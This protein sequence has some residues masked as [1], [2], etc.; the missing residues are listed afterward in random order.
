M[1]RHRF[2]FSVNPQLSFPDELR[3]RLRTQRLELTAAQRQ[4]AA[5]AAAERL[6]AS[7]WFAEAS[8]IAGYWA[9]KGELN[10]MPVLERALAQGKTVYLPVLA[11]DALQFAPWH[12]DIAMRRNRFQI[13]EPDV[14]SD[15]WLPPSALDLALTPL[16]AFDA[17]NAVVERAGL[18]VNARHVAQCAPQLSARSERARASPPVG[19]VRLRI[20]AS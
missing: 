13:P 1:L 15:E 9:F 11:G 10:P 6:A 18:G 20:P 7:T 2:I 8:R 16:V 5:W 14:S 12:P 17:E 4:T 3:Q 19:R